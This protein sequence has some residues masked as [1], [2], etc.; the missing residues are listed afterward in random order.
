MFNPEAKFD[1]YSAPSKQ[2]KMFHMDLGQNDGPFKSL[3]SSELAVTDNRSKF[4]TNNNS[5]K[6]SSKMGSQTFEPSKSIGPFNSKD[7]T[8]KE[9]AANSVTNQI[10][11]IEDLIMKGYTHLEEYK[12]EAETT[13]EQIQNLLNE[14]LD[15]NQEVQESLEPGI[16][17]SYKSLK[18]KIKAQ[19]DEN[20]LLY[21]HLLSIKKETNDVQ[22]KF[23]SWHFE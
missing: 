16:L 21:K 8:M 12:K 9:Q 11:I 17:E 7:E 1:D 20:E 15:K 6:K 4:T 18:E 5:Y 10:F 13:R 3:E 23:D 14:L 19:K 22:L 2:G